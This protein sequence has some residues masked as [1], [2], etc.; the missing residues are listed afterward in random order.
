MSPRA[1]GGHAVARTAAAA[2]LIALS[3]SERAAAQD[4]APASPGGPRQGASA[5]I[6]HGLPP[7]GGAPTLEAG[8]TSWY[9]LPGL[10]TRSLALATGWRSV[11]VAAGVSQTGDERSGWNAAGAA[12]GRGGPDAGAALRF[13]VRADRD[14]TVAPRARVGSE[15]GAGAW[16]SPGRAW[17]LWASA[18]QLWTDGEAPPLARALEAGACARFGTLAGW[19][20]FEAVAPGVGARGARTLGIACGDGP[21]AVWAEATDGPPRASLGLTARLRGLRLEARLDQHPVLA[22][23]TR[24]TLGWGGAAR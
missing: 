17:T 19:L 22:Q 4:F 5:F 20:A 11:R 7:A 18:P 1:C 24:L 8:L 21:V 12:L 2:I 23:T 3:A 10:A 15:A 9:S 16:V 13:V 14:G 6:E